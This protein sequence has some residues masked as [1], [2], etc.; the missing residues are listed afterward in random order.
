MSTE[1]EVVQCTT[2]TVV[3]DSPNPAQLNHSGNPISLTTVIST[4]WALTFLK[5][6]GRD[7]PGLLRKKKKQKTK[8]LLPSPGTYWKTAFW[9][10]YKY[11]RLAAVLMREGPV[12]LEKS[13]G[14]AWRIREQ[15]SERARACACASGSSLAWSTCAVF[16]MSPCICFI[17][18][19]WVGF[20][21]PCYPKN[22]N[23]YTGDGSKERGR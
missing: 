14:G 20:S 4:E 21:V 11:I 16:Y 19:T 1:L 3:S 17:E 23:Y 5:A 6:V 15:S 9:V 22:S 18:M 8:R 12:P 10:W 13:L 2:C 7:F